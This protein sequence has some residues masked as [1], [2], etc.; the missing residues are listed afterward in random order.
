M[1]LDTA[2]ERHE[3]DHLSDSYLPIS[4]PILPIHCVFKFDHNEVARLALV[5]VLGR[6]P[7]DLNVAPRTDLTGAEQHPVENFITQISSFVAR[8]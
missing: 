1:S 7:T 4:T 5:S 2:K 8:D 3:A 6:R